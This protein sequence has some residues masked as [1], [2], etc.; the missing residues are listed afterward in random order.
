[1]FVEHQ[2]FQFYSFHHCNGKRTCHSQIKTYDESDSEDAFGRVV[3]SIS[4]NP[5]RTSHGYRDLGKFVAS[6]DRSGKPEKIF[7]D[8]MQ[9]VAPHHEDAF[10]GGNAH[11]VRYGEIIMMDRGN[12]IMLTTK[13]S[14]NR[15]LSSWEVTLQNLRT[16]SKT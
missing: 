7:W 13:K 6:Y 3:F 14:Q 10:L 15:K 9:Q 5:E 8:M 2:Q 11:S 12:L 1:M 16:K 4:S